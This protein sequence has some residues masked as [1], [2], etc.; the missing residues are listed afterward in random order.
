MR[1]VNR[2]PQTLWDRL[3][4]FKPGTPV[5][6]R[7]AFHEK[8]SPDDVFIVNAVCI[9]YRPED[10]KYHAKICV[11]NLR[12]GHIGYVDKDRSC[13]CAQAHVVMGDP[14]EC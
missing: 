13:C 4:I 12:T 14:D 5:M 1:V 6:F 11:T 10:R 2:K 7:S 8:H 3:S 9:S